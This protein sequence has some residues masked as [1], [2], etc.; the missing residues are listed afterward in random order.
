MTA[1]LFAGIGGHQ[2]PRRG[3]TDVWLT[4]PW[5]LEM[6]GGWQAFDLD[7]CAAV[8]QP[9]RTA[10][11]HYT[12]N[13]NGLLLPRFGEVWCN[14]PYSRALLS[15]FMARIAEHGRGIAL[16]FA[17]TETATFFRHVWDRATALLFWR[18]RI[19]F[20]TPAGQPQPRADGKAANSG[21]P[22]VLCAYGARAAD[23]LA[24]LDGVCGQFVPLRLPRSVV[25]LALAPTWR[26][27]IGAWLRRQRGPVALADIY[28]A[29]S[30][31]P[32]T[33]GNPNYQAKIR[34]VLQEGA[35]VRVSRGQWSAA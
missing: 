34:Q 13:E 28:R 33:A 7:P 16:I 9:W 5:L 31:H 11:Q 24:G 18:G 10:R 20:Y 2:T 12:V 29:F 23:T 25:A 27:A 26:E 17:R 3:R 21:A 4:P 30:A 1:P 35:G 6:L 19:D 22:S 14:P 8:D 32:K 15:R